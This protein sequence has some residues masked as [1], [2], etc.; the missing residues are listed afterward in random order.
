VVA[1]IKFRFPNSGKGIGFPEYPELDV[2]RIIR[3]P[4]NLLCNSAVDAGFRIGRYVEFAIRPSIYIEEKRSGVL[5][6]IR[7]NLRREMASGI[8]PFGHRA[9]PI[10]VL[11]QGIGNIEDDRIAGIPQCLRR[12]RP[13]NPRPARNLRRP[14]VGQPNNRT[15]GRYGFRY[16]KV[17]FG[18]VLWLQ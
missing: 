11:W 5:P 4:A 18:H 13:P 15:K 17:G 14:D 9:S 3:I 6:D 1:V 8:C 10:H 7:V 2:R 16:L 12:P